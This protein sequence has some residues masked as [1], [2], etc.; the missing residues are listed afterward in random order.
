MKHSVT[1]EMD[2]MQANDESQV[3]RDDHEKS[4][5]GPERV[6]EPRPEETRGVSESISSFEG[7]FAVLYLVAF[8]EPPAIYPAMVDFTHAW[9]SDPRIPES[10]HPAMGKQP[11]AQLNSRTM[12][13]SDGKLYPSLFKPWSNIIT[14]QNALTQRW[15]AL[16]IDGNLAMGRLNHRWEGMTVGRLSKG[17]STVRPPLFDGTNYT[18]WKERMRIYIRS[19][20]FQLWLIIKNGETMPMKKVGETT[21]PKTKEEY[22]AEDIKKVEA[23]EKAKH[24]IFCAINPDYYRKISSCSTAKE[25]WDKLE[26]TYEGTPQVREAKIDFLTHEYELFKMKEIESVDQMFVRFLKIINDLHVLGKTYSNKDLVR[27]ILWSLTP[28]WHSKVNAI[29]ESIGNTNVTIDGLRDN[30]KTYESTILKSSLDNSPGLALKASSSKRVEVSDSDSDDH[31]PSYNLLEKFQEFLKEELGSRDCKRKGE[32]LPTCFGCG[33]LGHIKPY[34]PNRKEKKKKERA[35]MAWDSESSGDETATLCLMAHER[36]G[37]L[38][39]ANL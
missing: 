21:I 34:C 4:N 16:P 7:F 36:N 37:E 17:H 1:T 10:F 28:E 25:M 18:Y 38:S 2:P 8:L 27:K 6:K 23:F 22:D 11:S 3:E 14:R 19:I 31:N 13:N 26:V 12:P 35:Y 15:E 20:N 32:P 5:V 24:M 33:E 29:Y 30:L 9:E 39:R